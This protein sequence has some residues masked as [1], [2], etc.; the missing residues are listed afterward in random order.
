VAEGWLRRNGEEEVEGRRMRWH[1]E[2][3]RGG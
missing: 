2:E 3:E 1:G